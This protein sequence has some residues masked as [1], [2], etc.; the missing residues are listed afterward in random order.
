MFRRIIAV[1]VCTFLCIGLSSSRLKARSAQETLRLDVNLVNVFLTVQNSKGEY[2]TGLPADAFHVYEDDIEQKVSIFEKEDRVES[3]I[4]VLMDTSGSSVD[5]LPIIK[6]GVL[7]FA[8]KARRSDEFFVMSFGIR[9]ELIHDIHQSVQSLES[10]F[11]TLQ[12]RG[13]CV[14]FDAML[15]GMKKVNSSEHTRK[16]LIIFTDGQDN[17]SKAGFGETSLVAQQSSVLLYFI[18][19]GSRIHVD[20]PAVETLARLSGGRVIYLGKTDPIRPA[21][22][23]IRKDIANQYYIGYYAPLRP[24]LHRIRVELPGYDYRIHAKTGYMGS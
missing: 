3:A 22:E 18:P 17:G 7:D 12:P 13:N 19:I 21:M 1:F 4:G 11:K 6:T 14:L 2:V 10:E 15:A 5:I 20:Q 23:S 8:Q 24:G 9:A 16:A